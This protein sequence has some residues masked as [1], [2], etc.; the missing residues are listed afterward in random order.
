MGRGAA[1]R[2]GL[3]TLVLVACGAPAKP[4][5]SPP[6]A[7]HVTPAPIAPKTPAVATP[8]PPAFT[9]TFAATEPDPAP[10]FEAAFGAAFGT[11]P[12]AVWMQE[13]AADEALVLSTFGGV[14]GVAT[15]EVP[16]PAKAARAAR[17]GRIVTGAQLWRVNFRTKQLIR[18][19]RLID[20]FGPLDCDL[21]DC[22]DALTRIE[23]KKESIEVTALACPSGGARTTGD[24]YQIFDDAVARLA[25]A[26][27]GAFPTKLAAPAG[28]GDTKLLQK[29]EALVRLGE[30]FFRED[31]QIQL[32]VRGHLAVDGT[33]VALLLY[34]AR[35]SAESLVP[36]ASR[37]PQRAFDVW[38]SGALVYRLEIWV[39]ARGS[40]R[41]VLD[42][43]I[44][45]G[46]LDPLPAAPGEAPVDP[47]RTVDMPVSI[48]GDDIHVKR[49]P[50]CDVKRDKEP[51]A[52]DEAMH[53]FSSAAAR[54]LCAN[55]GV[56][57]WKNGTFVRSAR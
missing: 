31:G 49:D 6:A 56:L 21:D 15:H 55:A 19:K 39:A 14:I 18:G 53:S 25:C 36:V 3:W 9:P 51:D 46:P 43:P 42:L 4:A 47:P 28:A 38:K 33:K 8:S 12:L 34:T 41:R 37:A 45:L 27:V 7:Q 13:G 29:N 44:G 20:G 23:P 22:H 1:I 10:D 40:L 26:D 54:T 16:L 5:P 35:G 17:E 24:T 52:F 2:C 48:D 32:Q 30:T 50:R 57:R 11:P